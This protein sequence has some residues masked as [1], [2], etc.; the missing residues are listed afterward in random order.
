MKNSLG[1]LCYFLP[2]LALLLAAA[3]CREEPQPGTEPGLGSGSTT[4]IVLGGDNAATKAATAAQTME[5]IDFSDTGIDG[6]KLVETVSSLDDE[7]YSLDTKGTPIYTENFDANFGSDLWASDYDISSGSLVEFNGSAPIK[8]TN[9]AANTYSYTYADGIRWPESGLLYFF[10]APGAVTKGLGAKV[11]KEGTINFLYTVPSDPAQQKD[12]LFTSKMMNEGSDNH[13]LMYHALTAVKFKVKFTSADELN[14]TTV[15]SVTIKGLASS[16][17]CTIKPGY[18]GLNEK[19]STTS[20]TGGASNSTKSSDC[21]SW[22]NLGSATEYTVVPAD[23][24]SADKGTA[25]GVNKFADS[26]YDSKGKSYENNLNDSDFTQTM[27]L[28][29]QKTGEGEKVEVVIVLEINNNGAKTEYTRTAKMAIDWKAGE[30]HTYQFTIDKVDVKVDDTVSD[31]VK[32]NVTT[33]NTG[34]V[35]AYLRAG[36][37]IAWYYGNGD[38][39]IAVAPYLGNGGGF[40]SNA[41]NSNYWIK[42]DDGYYYYKY[43]V[44]PGQATN[45]ALFTTFTAPTKAQEA[46]FPKCHLEVTMLLQGVMY[47]VEKKDVTTAWGTVNVAGSTTTVVSQL[48]TTPEE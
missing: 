6:L 43:P 32:S 13:I 28:I 36:Y 1:K 42:G 4:T 47:D 35:T 16:G 27:M 41:F 7:Y 29:P 45:N 17:D 25:E 15:K 20:N 34:N 2:A 33:T 3:S 14:S 30:L 46:P 11:D 40:D 21:T 39:A 48:S 5:P 22:K 38:A 44:K 8:F 9:T 31:L 23:V 12:I 10:Q 24:V 37:T 18:V 19:P 26:F